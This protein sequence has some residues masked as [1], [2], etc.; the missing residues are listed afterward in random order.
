MLNNLKVNRQ[1]QQ[2]HGLKFSTDRPKAIYSQFP[3]LRA[4]K[5]LNLG[6]CW[7]N[8]SIWLWRLQWLHVIASKKTKLMDYWGLPNM[9]CFVN[10]TLTTWY[11]SQLDLFSILILHY[12]KDCTKSKTS[13]TAL[14]SS[15]TGSIPCL[16]SKCIE[17]TYYKQKH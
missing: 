10:M 14:W 5:F 3:V 8:K 2:Q 15:T 6:H 13:M 11:T 17:D 1:Q 12:I 16:C 9:K 7:S 4:M